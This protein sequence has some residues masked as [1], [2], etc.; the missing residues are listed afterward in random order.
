M[1]PPKIVYKIYSS[2]NFAKWFKSAV[3]RRSSRVAHII[4][5]TKIASKQKTECLQHIGKIDRPPEVV[6]FLHI[7]DFGIL[8]IFS[9]QVSKILNFD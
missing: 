3:K 6:I 9:S 8:R 2:R 7:C 4:W 5:E 1:M